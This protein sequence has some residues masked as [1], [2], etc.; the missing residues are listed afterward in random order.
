MNWDD[1]TF[2][3]DDI[4]CKLTRVPIGGNA[5]HCIWVPVVVLRMTYPEYLAISTE[6]GL[7]SYGT[8]AF[9]SSTGE[10]LMV[11]QGFNMPIVG[12]CYQYKDDLDVLH[13]FSMERNWSGEAGPNSN[14][15]DVKLSYS[16]IFNSTTDIG[17]TTNYTMSYGA[18]N[19]NWSGWT[20]SS[21]PGEWAG[22]FTPSIVVT[23]DEILIGYAD[24]Y[25]T[26]SSVND[27]V[28]N[29]TGFIYNNPIPLISYKKDGDGRYGAWLNWSIQ[30]L[31]LYGITEGAQQDTNAFN[32]YL[33]L[34]DPMSKDYN[35]DIPDDTPDNPD[36]DPDGDDPTGET[37]APIVP[38]EITGL[39][40]G[41]G[42]NIHKVTSEQLQ[43]VINKIFSTGDG[44]FVSAFKT[45]FGLGDNPFHYT[46][47]DLMGS[48]L[49]CHCIPLANPTGYGAS[50][51]WLGFYDTGIQD[52][53][54][55]NLWQNFTYGSLTV[56]K[57][58]AS[59]LDSAGYRR[60][61]IHVPFCGIHEL[62]AGEIYGRTL[63]LQGRMNSLTGQLYMYL[64]I[65]DMLAYTYTGAAIIPIP[66]TAEDCGGAQRALISAG[67]SVIAGIAT[68]AVGGAIAGAGIASAGVASGASS[69]S[70]SGAT[71]T[72]QFN[73]QSGMANTI[74][75]GLNSMVQNMA[76]A[77]AVSHAGGLGGGA[78]AMDNQQ[79]YILIE[80]RDYVPRDEVYI[81]TLGVPSGKSAT[82]GSLGTGAYAE[83]SA[84][85][86]GI[87]GATSEEINLA[88]KLLL[89]GV[90]V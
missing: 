86:L 40:T 15:I 11:L 25:P 29:Q 46:V 12:F 10:R 22:A 4:Q 16:V 21:N 77:P 62:D 55:I 44:S 37:E 69:A 74:G 1:G 20:N 34:T 27:Y 26:A 2:S 39:G 81:Q 3:L 82:L 50:E 33:L 51:I 79:A 19:I 65:D 66:L 67:V 57:N 59:F 14:K 8:N 87:S 13:N 7:G 61:Y 38:P 53:N 31:D 72:N 84:V 78:S 43:Q 17:S 24:L 47:S 32:T 76:Q 88:K 9:N 63:K 64:F 90:I 83:C 52:T 68:S 60:I 42:L 23:T 36:D 58:T 28:V 80:N 54:S 70:I 73:T 41:A 85:N 18:V 35:P 48:I 75:N 6:R 71:V 49:S 30:T 45:F 56:G 5:N 89:Q